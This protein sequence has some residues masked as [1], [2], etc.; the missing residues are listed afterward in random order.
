MPACQ[1][2]NPVQLHGA[3]LEGFKEGDAEGSF[4]A[5]GQNVGRIAVFGGCSERL[6]V[7]FPVL[8][9]L[10]DRAFGFLESYGSEMPQSDK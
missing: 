1:R 10:Q 2:V 4:G 5:G 7:S 8:S 6:Q 3:A 9:A